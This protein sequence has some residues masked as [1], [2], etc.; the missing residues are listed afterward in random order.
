MRFHPGLVLMAVCIVAFLPVSAQ[1]DELGKIFYIRS[2]GGIGYWSMEDLKNALDHDKAILQEEGI[3]TDYEDLGA[4][5]GFGVEAGAR[6]FS[7]I[8]VGLSFEYEKNTL[9]N[10][11]GGM[12]YFDDGMGGTIWVS[13]DVVDDYELSIWEVQANVTFWMPPAPGLYIGASGGL[14]SGSI[15]EDLFLS[16]ESAIDSESISE[17][18]DYEGSGFVGSIF[19]GY[20][21]EFTS[22][23]LVYLEAGYRLRNLGSFD[24]SF[25]DDFKPKGELT[26]LDRK[27]VGD[28]NYSGFYVRAGVGFTIDL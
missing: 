25:S 14:G 4:V 19:A 17:N 18:G 11:A 8:S 2:S 12:V 6:V 10:S 28:I 20:Q 13:Y 9:E 1:S 16:L 3:D 26:N 5:F 27:P 15:N 21:Y 7:F 22:A 23:P 24:G